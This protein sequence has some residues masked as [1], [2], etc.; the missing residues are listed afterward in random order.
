MRYC[1]VGILTVLFSLAISRSRHS[2]QS[3]APHPHCQAIRILLTK[4][5]NNCKKQSQRK[6]AFHK[7]VTMFLTAVFMT[8]LSNATPAPLAIEAAP[9]HVCIYMCTAVDF[10]G[11]CNNFCGSPGMC[12]MRFDLP[13][14]EQRDIPQSDHTNNHAEGERYTD[15][16]LL[17]LS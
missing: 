1:N 5:K 9:S 12:C 2:S 16:F 11:M 6:M 7:V 10:G 17:Q 3:T 15:I 14:L 4:Y 8:T 13:S